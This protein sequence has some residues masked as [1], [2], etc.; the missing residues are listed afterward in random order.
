MSEARP[1][2]GLDGVI[3]LQSSISDLGA[4]TGRLAY[5]G[6]AVTDLAAG[7]TFEETAYLLLRGDLPSR[8]ELAEFTKHLRGSQRLSSIALKALRLAPAGVDPMLALRTALAAAAMDQPA[9]LP[10]T[11]EAAW[12]QG[13]RLIGQ[14]P[15]AVAAFHRMRQA[16][17]PES[18]RKG[19]SFAANCLRML[20]GAE[21]DPEAA[22]DFD[23]ALILRADNELNPSTFAA[24]VTAATGADVFAGVAAATAA[25]SGPRHGWHTRNVIQMLEEIGSPDRVTAWL[26]RR[27]GGKPKIPGFGHQVYRGEDPRTALLRP[28]V[29]RQC[30]RAGLES[31]HRTARALEEAVVA[32]LD[33]HAIVDFYLAPLYRALGIPADLFPAI[34]AVSRMPGWVAHILEQYQDERLIRP[35]AEYVGPAP[36]S[37]IAMRRRR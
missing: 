17:R 29:E 37:Y 3:A 22:A 1:G 27:G 6:Y 32:R 36:R 18:P 26:E 5:R 30:R 21:P 25:L 34:F 24:R 9:S 13:M 33:Q 10:P 7:S 4:E 19:M 23:A 2:P 20:S 16:L 28:L 12:G 15:T 8:A 31:L 35:R 11:A 14:A